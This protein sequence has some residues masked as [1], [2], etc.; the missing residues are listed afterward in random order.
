M[1]LVNRGT[2]C[3]VKRD[4]VGRLASVLYYVVRLPSVHAI[5]EEFSYC[6]G[7]AACPW[8]AEPHDVEHARSSIW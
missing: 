3:E 1:S 7:S 6:F 8:A 4:S 5:P 2:R